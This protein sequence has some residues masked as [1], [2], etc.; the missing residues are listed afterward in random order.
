M[1][2]IEQHHSNNDHAARIGED[3]AAFG[4]AAAKLLADSIGTVGDGI[5][6]GVNGGIQAGKNVAD[7]AGQAGIAAAQIGQN[8]IEFGAYAVERAPH[9]A[10]GALVTGVRGV[11]QIGSSI[12]GAAHNALE[13]TSRYANE[14]SPSEAAQR[15]H[16]DVQKCSVHPAAKASGEASVKTAPAQEKSAGHPEAKHDGKQVAKPDMHVGRGDS[17]WTMAR[18]ELGQHASN[19]EVAAMMG[20]LQIVN[21]SKELRVGDA[22]KA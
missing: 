17:Y 2:A 21:G 3:S 12:S 8:A 5:K 16:A 11:G 22:I 19:A 13:A 18:K 20:H 10:A 4:S 1:T 6:I 7:A 14:P 9:L 15:L